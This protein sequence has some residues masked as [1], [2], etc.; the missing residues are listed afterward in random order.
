MIMIVVSV[1][2]I[3]I[4]AWQY[5][6]P[7]KGSSSKTRKKGKTGKKEKAKQKPKTWV[8]GLTLQRDELYQNLPD[9]AHAFT[10][11]LNTL[12]N[13]ESKRFSQE[14]SVFCAATKCEPAWLLDSELDDS[15]KQPV[16]EALAFY[17]LAHW[18]ATQAQPNI[19]TFTTFRAW[20]ADPASP[21]HQA[22]SQQL[23]SRLIAQGLISKPGLD[24]FTT[25]ETERRAYVAQAINQ[26]AQGDRE[27][28][29]HLFKEAVTAVEAPTGRNKKTVVANTST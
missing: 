22:L 1:F 2:I 14:L 8:T 10:T 9:E 28:F 15:L 26:A 18:Q 13:K 20:Q 17:C 11:W 4:V 21:T 6:D 12:S 16:E 27:T 7:D 23:F 3:G 5:Y 25:S 29:N 24:L 19:Q